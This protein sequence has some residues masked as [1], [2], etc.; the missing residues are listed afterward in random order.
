[1]NGA[2]GHKLMWRFARD[3]NGRTG[4]N[5]SNT[6]EIRKNDLQSS[7]RLADKPL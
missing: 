2:I 4:T 7:P 3:R 1:L 6:L 5:D